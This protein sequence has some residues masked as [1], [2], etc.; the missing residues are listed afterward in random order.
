MNTIKSPGVNQ[1]K[2]SSKNVCTKKVEKILKCMVSLQITWYIIMNKKVPLSHTIIIV[3]FILTYRILCI[4]NPHKHHRKRSIS[5]VL[6]HS[7]CY[8]EAPLKLMSEY[9]TS[10]EKEKREI[11]EITNNYFGPLWSLYLFIKLYLLCC[12]IWF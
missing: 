11:V 6:M 9:C 1:E 2:L 10:N 4:W 8:F 5:P 7:T 12:M 3:A